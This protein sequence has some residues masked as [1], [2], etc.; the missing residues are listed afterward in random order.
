MGLMKPRKPSKPPQSTPLSSSEP[1][2]RVSS[3]DSGHDFAKLGNEFLQASKFI[4]E[5]FKNT[6]KWPT[7]ETAFQALENYLKAYLLNKGATLDQVRDI[8]P[9]LRVALLEAKAKGLV[10][11][12]DPVVE[13]AVM[14][15]SDY[16][17][18]KSLGSGEWTSV[19]PHLVISFADQV[20]RD[21][22]L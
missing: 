1:S 10:L 16:Y 4:H 14:K 2:G 6:P 21:I 19:S 22:R 11:K 20:R 8:G 9:N 13:E 7:Y 3:S 18:A 5:G 17:T 12:V 15:V